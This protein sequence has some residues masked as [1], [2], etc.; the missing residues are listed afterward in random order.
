MSDIIEKIAKILN[1]AE[2]A[3]TEAEGEAFL[4][5]AQALSTKYSIELAEARA[6]TS[7]KEQ[8]E[9]PV[10]ETVSF[11]GFGR[12][13]KKHLVRLFQ[14]IAEA[15]DVTFDIAHGSTRVYPYGFPS[16][17]ELVRTLFAHLAMQMVDEANKFLTSG[18]YKAETQTTLVRRKV[19]HE[20]GYYYDRNKGEYY[21]WDNKYVEKPV[22]GRVARSNFYQSF[23]SRV[24]G[25]LKEARRETIA[26]VE[27]ESTGTELV[28]ADK[29]EEVKA[30]YK[31]TSTA[32][33]SWNGPSMSGFSSASHSAGSAAGA[34]ARLSSQGSVG[35]P[36]GA[37]TA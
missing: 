19:Y 11:D 36:R 27:A 26:E 9:N 25:R 8:R 29:A 18:A 22:D 34:R 30:F 32:K 15:N 14:Q 3:S 4:K 5:A 24:G 7:K 13:T 23:I 35:G 28:L 21:D 10:R 12:N 37:L 17:I 20:D 31:A 16:D 1:K 33:G 6:H 2:N